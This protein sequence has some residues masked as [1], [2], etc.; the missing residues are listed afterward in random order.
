MRTIP[1]DG[2]EAYIGDGIHDLDEL[3]TADV[4][5]AMGTAGSRDTAKCANVLVMTHDLT[6]L[7]ML[8]YQPQNAQYSGT[9]YDDRCHCENTAHSACTF[10][11][12]SDV[13][14]CCSGHH[15]LGTD[16]IQFDSN[17]EHK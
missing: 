13:A 17:P 9:E 7:L 15:P 11:L 2:A 5:I 8:S 6:R 4:G 12:C 1:T 16:G 14:C 10:R 3:K